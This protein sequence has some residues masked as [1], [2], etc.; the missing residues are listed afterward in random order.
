MLNEAK[1]GFSRTGSAVPGSNPSVP[2]ISLNDGTTGFGIFSSIPFGCFQ[3][4]Y[5]WKDILTKY[6]GKHNLKVGVEFRRGHDD[7]FSVAKPSYTFQ[8]ILDFAIDKPISENLSVDPKT[9]VAKGSNYEERTLNQPRLFKTISKLLRV[10][11]E[12]GAALGD[13]HHATENFGTFANFVFGT[14]P[15]LA[16]RIANGSM[17]LSSDPYKSSNLNFAP[18]FGYSWNP[19]SNLVLRGGFGI[20]YDR[21]PNGDWES[22]ANN[23]PVLASANAGPI[24][25]TYNPREIQVG[26]KIIF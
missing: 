2:Q 11:F 24:F 20:T 25:Q 10:D 23:P 9:G 15:T 5:E 6:Q 22:L 1:F 8:N 7:F 14:G 3:M 21:I 16:G 19:R 12:P 13:Y 18:R 26:L 4:N 17:Q